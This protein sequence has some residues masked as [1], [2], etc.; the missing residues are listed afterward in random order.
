MPVTLYVAETDETNAISSVWVK[1]RGKTTARVFDPKTHSFDPA[2]DAQY[3][4]A[5][6]ELIQAWLQKVLSASQTPA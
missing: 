2:E 4:G 3:H 6:Q 5:P 1:P